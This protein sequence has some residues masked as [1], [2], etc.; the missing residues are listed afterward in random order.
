MNE[1][2]PDR[3]ALQWHQDRGSGP[4]SPRLHSSSAVK[5]EHFPCP[6][7]KQLLRVWV[8]RPPDD[9]SSPGPP[10]R[11]RSHRTA[12]LRLPPRHTLDQTATQTN[13]NMFM[14]IRKQQ[15]KAKEMSNSV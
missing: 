4:R 15:T 9:G 11:H 12:A 14:F 7:Q 10:G 6:L 13:P 1:E 2:A 8:Q 5:W 3:A